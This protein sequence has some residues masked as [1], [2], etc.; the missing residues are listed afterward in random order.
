VKIFKYVLTM[1]V[2]SILSFLPV[3]LTKIDPVKSIVES[4]EFVIIENSIVSVSF[5]LQLMIDLVSVSLMLYG[6]FLV[7]CI[8]KGNNCKYRWELIKNDM[9][10]PEFIDD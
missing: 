3:L 4:V 7:I 10:V 1:I 2:V 9:F 6:N 8:Y 5:S